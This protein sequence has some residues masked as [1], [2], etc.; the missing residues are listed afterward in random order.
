MLNSSNRCRFLLRLFVICEILPQFHLSYSEVLEINSHSSDFTL[1]YLVL[2]ALK[3]ENLC[4][5]QVF[6]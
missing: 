1:S 4:S 2:S 6:A 3:I 5:I